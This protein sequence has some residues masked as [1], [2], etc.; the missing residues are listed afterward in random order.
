MLEGD[1][2]IEKS[3]ISSELIRKLSEMKGVLPS[4]IFSCL[5][6]NIITPKQFEY[7]TGFSQNK[8][9]SFMRG[10]VTGGEFVRPLNSCRP[11]GRMGGVF[12]K[13]DELVKNILKE[14]YDNSI[15]LGSDK[16]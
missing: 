15:Q 9:R 12:I 13:N 3:T 11:F 7:L 4:Q 5:Q 8:V 2:T 10:W 1:I 14:I 16:A 6:Y